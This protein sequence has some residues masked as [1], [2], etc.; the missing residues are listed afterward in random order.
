MKTLLSLRRA[1]GAFL[2]RVF[3]VLPARGG[4]S[5]TGVNEGASPEVKL[6][7]MPGQ[8]VVRAFFA[9]DPNFFGGVRVA[10]GD[11]NGDGEP[12]IITGAGPGGFPTVK[13]FNGTN[14]AEIRSFAAYNEAFTGGVFVAAGDVNGDGVADIITGSGAGVATQVK[15][16]NGTNSAVLASF[17]PYGPSFSGGV[18]VAG[19]DVNGDGFADIITGAGST[20]PHVKVFH[21]R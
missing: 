11:V 21:G 17:L 9:Y 18:L 5:V 12:D 15:V 8:S 6:Y 19:G 16:F 3:G 13:V 1:F 14:G 7:S 2:F 10:L 4:F 20:T